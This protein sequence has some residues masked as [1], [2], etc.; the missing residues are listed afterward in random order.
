MPTAEQIEA[1]AQVIWAQVGRREPW[2]QAPVAD[3][4]MVRQHARQILEAAL[5]VRVEWARTSFAA[6]D[7]TVNGEH[8]P[9]TTERE[10]VPSW[11]HLGYAI[12]RRATTGWQAVP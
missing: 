8:T 12:V 4:V 10:A 3:K 11:R 1:A 5:E 7:R 9:Q 6:L 2:D